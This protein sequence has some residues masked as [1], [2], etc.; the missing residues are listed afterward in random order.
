MKRPTSETVSPLCGPSDV[1][2]GFSLSEFTNV[3]RLVAND[4]CTIHTAVYSGPQSPLTGTK[5]WLKQYS[6]PDSDLQAFLH[7]K[8]S[9]VAVLHGWFQE[10][11][12][13]YAVCAPHAS[14][15]RKRKRET[16]PISN[17]EDRELFRLV[18]SATALTRRCVPAESLKLLKTR[19]RNPLRVPGVFSILFQRLHAKH[20]QTRLLTLSIVHELF[21]RSKLFRDH[22]C[23][24]LGA[25]MELVVGPNPNAAAPLNQAHSS[26]PPK[27]SSV[28]KHTAVDYVLTWCERFEEYYPTLL[29]ARQYLLKNFQRE[30][31]EVLRVREAKAHQQSDTECIATQI[32]HKQRVMLPSLLRESLPVL[33]RLLEQLDHQFHIL[34]P[35]DTRDGSED[36]WERVSDSSDQSALL[37]VDDKYTLQVAVPLTPVLAP[38]SEQAVLEARRLVAEVQAAHLTY[39]SE[40]LQT[41]PALPHAHAQEVVQA[42]HMWEAAYAKYKALGL[43]PK[44]PESCPTDRSP[45]PRKPLPRTVELAFQAAAAATPRPT[46]EE[47][48][49]CEDSVRVATRNTLRARLCEKVD[50]C[51]VNVDNWVCQ[52]EAEL[53]RVHPTRCPYRQQLRCILFNLPAIVTK[54]LLGDIHLQA[55]A[56]MGFKDFAPVDLKH[57]RS[58]MARQGLEA[59]VKPP[60]A[61][62]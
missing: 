33:F 1:L 29:L 14:H 28:L 54:L 23:D 40:A 34:V 48:P 12:S 9:R 45:E 39:L 32:S 41:L 43:E 13:L 27:V 26:P 16:L 53:F 38:G 50:A 51:Q 61:F 31:T 55:V 60:S 18:R 35:T 6:F 21:L 36:E 62:D 8:G 22:V 30:V 4:N 44:M 42:H 5:V 20:G 37:G 56:T 47:P 19:T 57:Q 7:D 2:S 58:K 46:S 25:L 52:M 15:L 17:P 24:K 59:A 10:G 49:P 3:V 11:T